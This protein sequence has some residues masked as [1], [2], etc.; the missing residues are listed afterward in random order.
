MKQLDFFFDFFFKARA[1]QTAAPE[2]FLKDKTLVAVG[3]QE[4]RDVIVIH[5]HKVHIRRRAYARHMSLTV[6][7]TRITLTAGRSVP[8]KM[9]MK[10]TSESWSWV[11]SQKS[12][13]SDLRLRFPQKQYLSGEQFLILGVDHALQLRLTTAKRGEVKQEN[14][15]LI[16]EVPDKY[17]ASKASSQSYIKE[18]VRAYYEDLGRR[19][20]SERLHYYSQKLKLFPREVGYRCQKTRWGSCS[21]SGHISF[22]WRLSAAPIEIID[23]VVVHELIHLKHANHSRRFWKSVEQ[24]IPKWKKIRLWLSENQYAFDFLAPKSELHES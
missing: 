6:R 21:S 14:G 11:E 18:Q 24:E 4:S 20:I 15:R 19:V 2:H 17:A 13:W 8:L 23:Y 3:R 1:A 22:N 10:F 7:P 16:V 5:G 9:L 12:V